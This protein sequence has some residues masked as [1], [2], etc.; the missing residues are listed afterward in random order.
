M[1]LIKWAFL[2]GGPAFVFWSCHRESQR[3]AQRLSKQDQE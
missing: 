1:E 2:L 3:E